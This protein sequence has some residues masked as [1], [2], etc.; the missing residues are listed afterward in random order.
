MIGWTS[1][2]ERCARKESRKAEQ[3]LTKEW[4]IDDVDRS[5]GLDQQVMRGMRGEQLPDTVQKKDA[6]D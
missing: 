2:S 4:A 1:S 6:D 3:N 5:P